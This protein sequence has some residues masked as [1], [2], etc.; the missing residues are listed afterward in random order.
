MMSPLSIARFLPPGK[1]TFDILVIDEASQVCSE[2]ALGAAARVRQL[3][4]VGDDQQ[5]P[6]TNFFKRHDMSEDTD[7][8]ENVLDIV[9]MESILRLCK[10]R[11]MAEQTL[12]WHY[13]SR[14]PS[15]MF[16]SNERF[17]DNKLILPPSPWKQSSEM[18]LFLHRVNKVY[19]KTTQSGG[20]NPVEAQE[21]VKTVVEH[22]HR[23]PQLSVGIVAF[24]EKQRER[25]QMELERERRNN[26]E[27][28][29]YFTNQEKGKLLFVKN[30]ENVQ[31]DERDVILISVGYG[32]HM[33][34]GRLAS[35]NFGPVN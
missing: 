24:S 3:V 28:N 33:P 15:L 31:G 1:L 27:L 29:V 34:G 25:I 4:V 22:M 10:A 23:Q 35:L 8:E 30:L 19:E 14:T 18:G 6:P 17:Y 5:L 21:L 32:P 20:T 9:D 13:R 12:R 2:N 7:D 11:G 26:N 16:V